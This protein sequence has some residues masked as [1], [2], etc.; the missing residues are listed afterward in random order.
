M[1]DVEALVRAEMTGAYDLRVELAVD[2]ARG[3]LGRPQKAEAQ[4]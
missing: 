4:R 3:H 1:Q 2:V